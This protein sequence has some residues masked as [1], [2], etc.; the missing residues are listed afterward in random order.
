LI[1][2]IVEI[3]IRFEQKDKKVRCRKKLHKEGKAL[4]MTDRRTKKLMKRKNR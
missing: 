3:G 1:L 4:L 2:N